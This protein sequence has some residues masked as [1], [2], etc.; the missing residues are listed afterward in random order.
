MEAESVASSARNANKSSRGQRRM[1]VDELDLWKRYH[2][3][4][5]T[6]YEELV[7]YYLPL[8]SFWV[9]EISRKAWWANKEDLTQDGIIGLIEAIKNFDTVRD[10]KFTTYARYYIRGGI[11]KSPELTRNMP[12]AQY[13]NYR[14]VKKAHDRLMQKLE[15]EPTVNEIAEEI[16]ENDKL[17]IE[18]IED[19]LAAMRIAFLE[20]L[21]DSVEAAQPSVDTIRSR[22]NIL[23]IQDAL[24]NLS[25]R[26][27][28]ILTRR[29]WAGQT[30][31]EIGEKLGLKEDTVN[32]IYHRAI[33]K[34]KELYGQ[35][36][37]GGRH[38]S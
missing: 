9:K 12:R 30:Y 22:E 36:S 3:G 4:D 31:S 21:T 11:Y 29:C 14:R 35:Q 37:E 2:R 38:G 25:E 17:T 13:K 20:G 28:S 24:S 5:E 10:I 27:S 32:K 16:P 23:R 1:T 26:E 33:I 18:E 8:V 6:A 34:L 15:R 19:A 7:L